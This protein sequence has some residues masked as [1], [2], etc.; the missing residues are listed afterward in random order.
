M[1]SAAAPG[2]S[3]T[4][5]VPAKVNLELLVGARRDDGY[6]DLS[7]VFQAVSVYDDVTVEPAEEWGITVTGPYADL[8][9]VDGT[10]LAMR[11]ARTLADA[12]GVDE[13]VHIAIH[14]E[15]PV[16]GGMAG[17]SADGA[18]TLVACDA[19]WDLSSPRSV[20]DDLA[21]DLGADVPFG[22]HG[23]T[24]IGSGRG[25]QLAP[26]LGRGRYHWV[27][28]LS[29]VG[30]STP[31]IYAEC[32]RLRGSSPVPDPQPSAPMMTALRSGDSDALGRA[33]TNDLQEAALHL[34]PSLADV[35]TTGMECGA[36]G[37]VVSG[38]GPT[39]AFLVPDNESALDLAVAL[40]ASGVASSVKRATGPVAGAHVL[41]AGAAL[42]A[43]SGPSRRGAHGDDRPAGGRGAS[44]RPG[45]GGSRSGRPGSGGSGRPPGPGEPFSPA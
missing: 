13:P 22:L 6:H 34:Q 11:A 38:S 44:R 15:I 29:D 21:A 3:V 27:F 45:S 9:P 43:P 41:S 32:D 8:V 33:L 12:A 40:T 28:A 7:T 16:A 42:G 24:A 2:R 25:D 1:T 5:R 10:N 36:L 4:A 30:L 35:L 26:V 19:L 23:G 31:A 18:A 20:L 17:G 37:G 39:V 14:K